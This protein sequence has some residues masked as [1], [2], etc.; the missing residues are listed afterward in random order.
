VTKTTLVMLAEP[1]QRFP[2][3]PQEKPLKRLGKNQWNNASHPV[4]TG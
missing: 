3:S 4:E 1:F 2:S